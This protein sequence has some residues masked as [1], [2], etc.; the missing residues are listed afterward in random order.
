MMYLPVLFSF[1]N[2]FQLIK[3]AQFASRFHHFYY[4]LFAFFHFMLFFIEMSSRS[5][6]IVA[7]VSE[8]A[9]PSENLSAPR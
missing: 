7:P 4:F 2:F 3:V 6:Y 1:F 9:S 5:D 8:S